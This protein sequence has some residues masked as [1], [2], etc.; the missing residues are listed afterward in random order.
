MLYSIKIISLRLCNTEKL[1]FIRNKGKL[2][3]KKANIIL[4]LGLQ[5]ESTDSE[6]DIQLRHLSK[7]REKRKKGRLAKKFYLGFK[8]RYLLENPQIS[9][10]LV[11]P[12]L[13]SY[14]GPKFCQ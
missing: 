8:M 7:E 6:G 3:V 4:F 12:S 10:T 11:F 2:T 1:P 14:S 5:E 9:T 13:T